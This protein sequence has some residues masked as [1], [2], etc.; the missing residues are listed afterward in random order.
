[1]N[2]GKEILLK[3]LELSVKWFWEKATNKDKNSK[4]YGLVLDRSNDENLCSVASVGYALTNYVIGV[5]RGWIDRQEA[6]ERTRGTLKTILSLSNHKGFLPHFF[7][8]DKAEMRKGTEYST[9][10]TALMAQ[11]AIT[12]ESFF[13]DEEIT[14]LTTQLIERVDWKWISFKTEDNRHLIHMAYNPDKDGEYVM[15]GQAGFIWHWS[16]PAEQLM[17][18]FQAAATD[19]IDADLAKELYLGFSRTTMSYN[20][21]Q[22]I[23]VPGGALFLHQFSH[24]WFKFQDYNDMYGF[25]WF[26][27]AQNATKVAID[28]SVLNPLGL[29]GLN[30]HAWGMSASDCPTGYSVGG[31]PPFRYGKMDKK[32]ANQDGT[33]QPYS[34]AAALPYN[35]THVEKSILWTYK[36]H[37]QTWG[38]YGFYESYNMEGEKPWYGHTYLGIDKGISSVMID[39]HYFGTTWKYYM[40]SK[41]IK[42]AI[43]KLGFV[44]VA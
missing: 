30:E 19:G 33:I 4:G 36:N 35:P 6:I 26:K 43:D 34:M 24:A 12:A 3:E 14:R 21:T 16:M 31:L 41:F 44:K 29:K 40:E 5:E 11:G 32:T 23:N 7:T 28:F 42:K 22:Y 18:Y 1:M 25:S 2:T 27:N 38:E 20:G 10:D 37:P 15:D 17:M 9:I 13:K 39:N 8:M